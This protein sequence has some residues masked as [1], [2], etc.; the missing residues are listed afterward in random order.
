MNEHQKAA[1]SQLGA[2]LEK[3]PNLLGPA[4]PSME[5]GEAVAEFCLAFIRKYSDGMKQLE[6]QS[7]R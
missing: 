6:S 2:L 7:H 4:F 1:L 3:Q 5:T